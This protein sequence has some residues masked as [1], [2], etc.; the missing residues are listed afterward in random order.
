M[1][2][3]YAKSPPKP[4]KKDYLES[5]KTEGGTLGTCYANLPAAKGGPGTSGATW[6]VVMLPGPGSA[7]HSG[8]FLK[9]RGQPQ[10]V[11]N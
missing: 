7:A 8:A 3:C 4:R 10:P 2:A 5:P 11:P 6:P 9:R 1:S